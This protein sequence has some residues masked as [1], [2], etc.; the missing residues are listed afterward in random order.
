MG[1]SKDFAGYEIGPLAGS[2]WRAGGP[3]STVTAD[4]AFV[5]MASMCLAPGATYEV[6]GA[7]ATSAGHARALAIVQDLVRVKA[8]LASPVNPDLLY[9]R[10]P[11]RVTCIEPEDV[12]ALFAI[13]DQARARLGLSEHPTDLRAEAEARCRA[14]RGLRA[15]GWDGA[16]VLAGFSQEAHMVTIPRRFVQAGVLKIAWTGALSSPVPP[17]L[18]DF[19]LGRLPAYPSHTV[20]GSISIEDRKQVRTMSWR[21]E[22]PPPV[23]LTPPS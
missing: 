14:I 3:N 17:A 11:P 21:P 7:I 13:D 10:R 5:R 19:S 1:K 4:S 12:P 23:R 8:Q 6:E 22:R 15:E 20:I 16:I 9:E 2:V 18:V